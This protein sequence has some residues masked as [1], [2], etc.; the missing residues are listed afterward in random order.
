MPRWDAYFLVESVDEAIKLLAE[1]HEQARIIAGGTDLMIELGRGTRKVSTL[2]DISKVPGL[3]E[4]RMGDDGY[5]HIGPTATHAQVAASALI[6]ERGLPLAQ[7]CWGVAAPAIRNQATVAGNLATASPA[8]DTITA[9]RA[10]D[11]ELSVRSVRGTRAIPLDECYTGVRRTSIEADELI[12]DIRFRPLTA[13]HRAVYLKL[14]LRRV[15]AIAVV[16]VAAVLRF[17]AAGD[18]IEKARLS[19]G[20]VAPTIVCTPEAELSLAG[21]RLDEAHIAEAARL[22]AEG[23]SPI[24]DVRGTAWFRRAEVEALVRRGLAAIRDGQQ[25]LGLP[26]PEDMVLLR[27][28][29]PEARAVSSREFKAGRDTIECSVNGEAVRV[30]GAGGKSLLR[31]LRE[32]LGL[33]GSKP[34]CEEGECGACTVWIDGKAV[35]ACLTPAPQAHGARIVTIEGLGEAGALHPVQQAFVELDAVQCGYCTPGFVMSAA[36]LLEEKPAPARAQIVDAL[37]GNICRC[38]GY[39]KIIQAVE[40]AA[41]SEP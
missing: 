3:D 2:V 10:L 31:M 25:R 6:Q 22:M 19:M 8:N 36:K 26:R 4:I 21:A 1:H 13:S 32:D 40:R 14:G 33:K 27:A 12:A 38:T 24:D 23:A 35:L 5:V 16:N 28:G 18:R 41:R 20:C 29:E 39:Y 37:S 7:A 17:D 9:L 30:E 15:L 11:G 34:G